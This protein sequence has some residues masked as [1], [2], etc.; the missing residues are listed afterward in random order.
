MQKSDERPCKQTNLNLPARWRETGVIFSFFFVVV[1]VVVERVEVG[2]GGV[3]ESSGG[4]IV[5]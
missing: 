2:V 3:E 5:L 4:R 1:V